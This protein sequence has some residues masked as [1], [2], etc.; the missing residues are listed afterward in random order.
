[1][2]DHCFK[3][4]TLHGKILKIG[5]S[6]FL[7]VLGTFKSDSISIV[8]RTIY[9]SFTIFS[10]I[11]STIGFVNTNDAQS[12]LKAFGVFYTSFMLNCVDITLMLSRKKIQN[13]IHL[14]EE[15]VGLHCET[16]IINRT[17]QF[18]NKKL[19]IFICFHAIAGSSFYLPPLINSLTTPIT[20]SIETQ[21]IITYWFTC[22]QTE[23]PCLNF[24]SKEEL[25]GVNML[26]GMMAALQHFGF[27][28][29]T[30][31]YCVV[32]AE[33]CIHLDTFRSKVVALSEYSNRFC[34]NLDKSSRN[35]KRSRNLLIQYR[36]N[37]KN[38]FMDIVKYQQFIRE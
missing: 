1:M 16:D 21:K 18:V 4:L 37:A 9:I 5:V 27:F 13:L 22:G 38:D 31:L 30:M 19:F 20:E 29:G 6:I 17:A 26:M 33:F 11:G 14:L 12:K 15:N 34:Y 23:T 32:M 36:N 10:L 35:D 3:M 8:Y 28:S 2:F 24:K 7:Y 25:L